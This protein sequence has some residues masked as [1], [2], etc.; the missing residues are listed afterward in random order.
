MAGV[1]QT[2]SFV[3]PNERTAKGSEA[4]VRVGE[5]HNLESRR[6]AAIGALHGVRNHDSGNAS[7]EEPNRSRPLCRPTFHKR[8]LCGRG[9][10]PTT[11]EKLRGSASHRLSQPRAAAA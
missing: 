6:G 2:Y 1:G 5:M 4:A 7:R 8:G 3:D 11:I 9:V 10:W